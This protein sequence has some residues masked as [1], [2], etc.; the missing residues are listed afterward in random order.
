MTKKAKK[1]R[2]RGKHSQDEQLFGLP[3][4]QELLRE[5][6]RD[7]SFLLERGYAEKSAAALVGNRYQLQKR[8]IQALV[9]MSCGQS[10][11]E[12]RLAKHILPPLINGQKVSI[13]G[14]NLLVG[15]EVALSGGY[16]F[17]G[18][19]SCYRDIAGVHGTY[20]SVEETL[21][22][23]ELVAKVFKDLDVKRVHWY[24][25]QPVSNSGRMK[26]LIYKLA[27]KHQLNWTA[28]TV[29]NP[30]NA[31][32]QKNEVTVSSDGWILDRVDA[33]TNLLQFIV[34][35]YIPQAE[36]VRLY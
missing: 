29:Q 32:A 19:D 13:D 28:D 33:W 17:E 15:L 10:A 23:L 21:P 30:D 20:K 8:Q 2:H 22:A 1:Q 31:L 4:Q 16:L 36:V 7:L 26:G 24:F 11:M 14:F 9:R 12:Q 18:V 3:K 25:D 34:T 35:N 6:V 27:D 5:A